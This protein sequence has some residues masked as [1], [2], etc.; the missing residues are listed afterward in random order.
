MR[1]TF[2]A[3][4]MLGRLA[5]WLRM[6]GYDTVYAPGLS[7][8]E[9]VR[10]AFTEGRCLLTRRTSLK[11]RNDVASLLFV[12]SDHVQEQLRQVILHAG[13]RPEPD[14]MFSLCLSCNA[15]LMPLSKEGAEGT[16]PEYVLQTTRR[17]SKCPTCGKVFW[18]GSHV[19]SMLARL[20][21]L[22]S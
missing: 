21:R 13:V 4:A 20:E 3:D 19:S 5:K 6:L 16:V 15:A 18:K 12:E 10:R 22:F 8:G 11:G 1:P 17:F 7:E 2:L 9:I 14:A